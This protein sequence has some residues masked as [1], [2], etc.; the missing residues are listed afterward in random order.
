MKLKIMIWA[1]SLYRIANPLILPV[2]PIE[3]V[4]Q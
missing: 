1:G 3:G 4:I 2:T